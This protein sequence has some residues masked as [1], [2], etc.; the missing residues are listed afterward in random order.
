MLGGIERM[1]KA[2][3]KCKGVICFWCKG[4]SAIGLWEFVCYPKSPC[5]NGVPDL[6]F[7]LRGLAEPMSQ[8]LEEGPVVSPIAH[9]S[10]VRAGDACAHD[11]AVKVHLPTWCI[12]APE[13][14]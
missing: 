3:C 5:L 9:V 1:A 4:F 2:I 12:E 6:L 7:A 13:P 11:L 14:L 10:G 8:V